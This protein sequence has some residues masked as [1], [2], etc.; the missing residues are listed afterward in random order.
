MGKAG[1]LKAVGGDVPTNGGQEDIEIQMP[2]TATVKIVGDSDFLFHRWMPEAINEKA[3]AAKGSKAKK[4]DNLESYVYRTESG[5][6]GIPGEY[7]RGAIIHAAKFRQDPRSPRKSA[8][9]LFKAG[10]I[11]LTPI[12][13][14][15]KDRWDYEDQRRVVIQR[16][17]VNRIRP[18]IRAGWKVEFRFLVNLPEYI[19]PEMLNDVIQQAGR[20]IGIG[21]FRPTY[22]RF[23]VVAFQRDEE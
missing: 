9:D 12:A 17:G 19:S 1:G 23:K 22:G 16:N 4:T 21:D 20:L 6:L 8:M 18:A 7:L 2:Y 10:I 11:S 13:S 15:G 14:L 3:R 5:D